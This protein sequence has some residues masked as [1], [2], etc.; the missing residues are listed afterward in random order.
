MPN[1]DLTE[2]DLALIGCLHGRN[3]GNVRG[4][5]PSELISCLQQR[6]PGY[7]EVMMREG[8]SIT[9]LRGRQLIAVHDEGRLTLTSL[10]I[11]LAEGLALEDGENPTSAG[12]K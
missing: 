6:F 1:V 8:E 10:G 7:D 11:E 3:A 2:M 5:Q 9:R 12:G 4:V